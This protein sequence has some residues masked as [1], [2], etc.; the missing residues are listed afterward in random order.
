MSVQIQKNENS[1]EKK[2]NKKTENEK[3]NNAPIMKKTH[4]HMFISDTE[5]PEIKKTL[6]AFEILTQ[7]LHKTKYIQFI[8][9]GCDSFHLALYLVFIICLNTGKMNVKCHAFQSTNNRV[10]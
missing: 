8:K 4:Q 1:T 6:N 2:M 5:F 10:R 7:N 9:N 3:N